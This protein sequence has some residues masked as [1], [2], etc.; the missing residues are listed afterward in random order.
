MN[1]ESNEQFE[2]LDALLPGLV[3]R[4]A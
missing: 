1:S 2:Q 4:K 3:A